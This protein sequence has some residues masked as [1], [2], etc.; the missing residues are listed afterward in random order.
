LTL[1]C[2]AAARLDRGQGLPPLYF[3]AQYIIEFTH[4]KHGDQDSD[5]SKKSHLVDTKVADPGSLSRIPDLDFSI[6]VPGSG[7]AAMK[8]TKN[9][10]IFYPKNVNKMIR[11]YPGSGFFFSSR[12][13][14][15][16]PDPGVKK[17]QD[18]G[19]GSVITVVP[20]HGLPG[21][22]PCCTSDRSPTRR[23]GTGTASSRNVTR[24]GA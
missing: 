11:D 14:I 1:T 24:D 10:S 21:G 19:S 4:Y 13:L 7:S 16:I 12:I 9:L 17:T 23:V 3:L 5:P 6:P 20:W 8:V 18:P 15:R 22:G 2:A